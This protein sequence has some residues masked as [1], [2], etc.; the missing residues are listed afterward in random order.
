ME[1]SI[2]RE[3]IID[4]N[5]CIGIMLWSSDDRSGYSI[6]DQWDSGVMDL[7]KCENIRLEMFKRTSRL[8][9]GAVIIMLIAYTLI[10]DYII[11]NNQDAP[12]DIATSS[13]QTGQSVFITREEQVPQDIPIPNAEC[14]VDWECDTG[15]DQQLTEVSE[16]DFLQCEG[17]YSALSSNWGLGISVQSEL[18]PECYIIE[19]QVDGG[20]IRSWNADTK[21]PI[22]ITG[23]HNRYP[24]TASWD[25]NQGSI[26]WNP[27]NFEDSGEVTI[28]ALIYEKDKKNALACD[29][30]V[31]RMENGIW[32]NK[33]SDAS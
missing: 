30:L 6:I 4:N 22:G 20:M 10:C 17:T 12:S 24:A 27:I 21:K 23:Q 29:E 28:R 32:Q 9:I 33:K 5:G 11:D 1:N 14:Q 7:R 26:I 18:L 8:G 15:M 3:L 19:W 31:L 2:C 16:H 25:D 13:E